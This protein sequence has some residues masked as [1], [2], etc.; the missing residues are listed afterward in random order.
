MLQELLRERFQMKVRREQREF[1]VYAMTI[2]RNVRTLTQS[3]LPESDRHDAAHT[4]R[5]LASGVYFGRL[6]PFR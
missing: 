4:D 1:P 5:E 3:A 2:A 6:I